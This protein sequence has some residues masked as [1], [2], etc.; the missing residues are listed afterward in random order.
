ML[1]GDFKRKQMYSLE[2]IGK[3]EGT[4]PLPLPKSK[5]K[6]L[7]Q[8]QI[9]GNSLQNG[10]LTEIESVGDKILPE[11]YQEVEYIESTGTQ[12]ID[13]QFI[14]NQDTRM[15]LDC[16][17]KR[18]ASE[19]YIGSSTT[20]GR[21]FSI[22]HD[23]T[24]LS[25]RYYSNTVFTYNISTGRHILDLNKNLLY[26]DNV[27]VKTFTKTTFTSNAQISICQYGS[28]ANYRAELKIY[29][30]KIWDNDT[31]VRD[32]VPC[33]RKSDNVIGMY[34]L[35]TNTFFTNAGDGTFLKGADLNHY[36]I[37]II[38][39]NDTDCGI[40]DLG[41]LTW[42]GGSS[43]FS[44]RLNGIKHAPSA[45]SK[46]NIYCKPYENATALNVFLEEKD[47]AIAA[48]YE[49]DYIWI[50]DTEYTDPALFKA[51][52]NGVYLYYELGTSTSLSPLEVKYI[53][54]N[55]PL[56]KTGDVADYIDFKRQKVVRNVEV[57]DNTGTLP[58]EQSLRPLATPTEE[59]ISLPEI[60]TAKD[61]CIL[62]VGTSV[63]PSKMYAEYIKK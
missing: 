27:L 34:D 30:S 50:R 59:T 44:A 2:S 61:T 22:G 20:S 58:I 35:V 38:S 10:T 19:R 55:E 63:Q 26:V 46:G 12:Y 16:G 3:V 57:I 7:K 13:T 45:S 33:Y 4:P 25:V 9:Y 29:S 41:S 54:L 15:F 62:S 28:D 21:A 48:H 5:G 53:Y 42:T 31:L 32:F 11:E 8:Y 51:H 36:K 43:Y 6:A 14:P 47:K 17:I 39:Y 60:L 24:D 56:R 18:I 49:L 1:Y 40:V 52:L 23:T 37:P